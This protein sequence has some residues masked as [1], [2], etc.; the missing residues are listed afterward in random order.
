MLTSYRLAGS[1]R[2][3]RTIARQVSATVEWLWL[4]LDA[5]KARAVLPA[6][7]HGIQMQ[8]ETSTLTEVGEACRGL[9]DA[10]T[11]YLTA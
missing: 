2:R 5:P 8:G 4:A 10:I 6:A 9:A 1:V 7:M 11:A 3:Q